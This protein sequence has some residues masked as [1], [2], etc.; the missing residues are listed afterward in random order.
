MCHRYADA[1]PE[2]K[3]IFTK[4]GYELRREWER[5]QIQRNQD[6]FMMHIFNDWNGYGTCE[7]MENMVR[8]RHVRQLGERND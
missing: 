3:M 8:R 7:V 4:K 5:E 2:E 6:N 1:N